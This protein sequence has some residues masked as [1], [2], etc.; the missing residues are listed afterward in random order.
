MP[1]LFSKTK[2]LGLIKVLKKLKLYP[3]FRKLEASNG[4]NV[5]FQKKELVMMGS[6]NY[7]GLTHDERVIEASVE[8]VRKWGTGCTGSRFLN[9]NLA[10]HEELEK[11][12]A[13]FLGF[14]AC[15]VFASGFLANQGAI[16]ALVGKDDEIFSDEENHACIIEGAK[17]TR[18][19]VHVYKHADMESLE[20]ALKK[21]DPN[22]AKL[23]ITDGVFSMT[24]H[25]APFDEIKKLADTYGARTYV[26][27]AHGL[28]V[29]GE[30]GRG[31]LSHFNTMSDI[32]MGTFSKSLASQGGFICCSNEIAEW[33]RLKARTFMFSA[34]L[35]PSAT[36]AALKSLQ[37][38]KEEPERV[39]VQRENARYLKD[40]FQDAGLDTMNSE[41][42][43]IPVFIGDD[44]TAL[45][46]CKKLLDLGVF[47]TP[48][49]FPAVPRGQAVIRCSVMSTHTTEDLDRAVEAFS[50]LAPKIIKANRK[51]NKQAFFDALSLSPDMLNKFVSDNLKGD[52]R[53]EL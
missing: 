42:S 20:E 50:K 48:V 29:I 45:M 21:S 17:L 12:L 47:T 27:D 36:A 1:D 51:P 43:V 41:T 52:R 23:I 44:Q 5:I 2:S 7:L 31:T 26:D 40:A 11:E 49:V 13:D 37:I 15:V 39:R 4:N 6:N 25:I 34:G 14:E 38:L 32:Y 28:G 18:A 22:K 9:G 33:L 10:L 35:A 30:G 19:K 3:F 8:A 46:M 53:P 16:S 24:G